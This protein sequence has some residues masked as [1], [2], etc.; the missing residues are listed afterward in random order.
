MRFNQTSIFDYNFVLTSSFF[1]FAFL[2]LLLLRTYVR[3]YVIKL[4]SSL[5]GQIIECTRELYQ[6]AQISVA[7]EST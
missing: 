4:R 2:L 1:L 6:F 5:L 3:R 7:E